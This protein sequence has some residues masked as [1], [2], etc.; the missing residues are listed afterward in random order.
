MVRAEGKDQAGSIFLLFQQEDVAKAGRD[1]E[2]AI[3]V[4]E[5]EL[6]TCVIDKNTTN[7]HSS[8]I[9]AYQQSQNTSQLHIQHNKTSSVINAL[10]NEDQIKFRSP[11]QAST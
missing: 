7:N 2:A 10:E 3:H 4:A 9:N 11:Q 5:D 6:L 8:F 1:I